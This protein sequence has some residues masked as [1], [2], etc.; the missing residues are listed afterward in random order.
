MFMQE[1]YATNSS[2]Q[3]FKFYNIIRT[4]KDSFKIL[5]EVLRE[6]KQSGAVTVLT[7]GIKLKADSID[8]LRSMTYDHNSILGKGSYGTMVFKG[9]L[10]PHRIAV[11]RIKLFDENENQVDREIEILKTCDAHENIVR[12]LGSKK[13]DNFVLILLELCDMNLKE[14]VAKKDIAI[15]PLEVLR[16]V[17]VGLEWL[18]EH[19]I[20]HR[21]LKPENILL[22]R[23]PIKVKISDF[24]LS[25]C[26]VE[27]NSFVSTASSVD[28][29][30]G[31]VAPEILLL[32][33]IQGGQEAGKFTYASDIFALGCLYYYI[34]TDGKHA[35]GDNSI[36][37][38][39][40]ILDGKSTIEH[41]DV[42]YGCT[43]NLLFV[44]RMISMDPKL[45]PS[46]SALLSFPIF[47]TR[48][49]RLRFLE[50]VRTHPADEVR[51]NVFN[52]RRVELC[53]VDDMEKS[54]VLRAIGCSIPSTYL[55]CQNLQGE[56]KQYDSSSTSFQITDDHENDGA[57]D[58][59]ASLSSS[60]SA[61]SLSELFNKPGLLSTPPRSKYEY[62]PRYYASTT[63][64]S[65]AE[66]SKP[67]EP[68][69]FVSPDTILENLKQLK[70]AA[71]IRRLFEIIKTDDLAI[72]KV[73]LEI[74]A[75][76]LRITEIWLGDQ[77][78]L[79]HAAVESREYHVIEYLVK[80]Q[81]FAQVL[82]QDRYK[83]DLIHTCIVD[84]DKVDDQRFQEKM[85]ILQLLFESWPQLTESKDTTYSR[86]PLHIATR[87][88]FSNGKK[89]EFI[90][91]L[92]QN[93][94]D[95][96][97]KDCAGQTPLHC[98][99]VRQKPPWKAQAQAQLMEIVKLLLENNANPDAI[100]SKSSTFLHVAALHVTPLIFHELI[101]HLDLIRR[102]KSFTLR[103]SI[104][105]TAL[106]DAI[107]NFE[108]LVTT[109]SVF[110]SN[111]FDFKATD[112]KN[113]DTLMHRAVKAGRMDLFLKVLIDF[114]TDWKVVNKYGDSGLHFA[115][116][117]GNLLCLKCLISLGADVNAKTFDGETPL[118]TAFGYRNT[119][120][121][122][123]V[124]LLKNGADPNV[125]T[126]T[127]KLPLH[128]AEERA[129]SGHVEQKT[130]EMLR[131]LQHS[132]VSDE[133]SRKNVTFTQR[134][135]QSP[136]DYTRYPPPPPLRFP[137]SASATPQRQPTQGGMGGVYQ[138][139]Y[140]FASRG[141]H[142]HGNENFRP[143]GYR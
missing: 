130:V 29:T 76:K 122:I 32:Q 82:S 7:D 112:T 91:M 121:E 140:R 58:V 110:K 77:K 119:V 60:Q 41:K 10:G 53:K 64:L 25:R 42:R 1:M 49:R 9:K 54:Q 131:N 75:K 35:F 120:H 55:M 143:R 87:R 34:L 23:K 78:T 97:A 106:H 127:G 109:L 26:I 47:W 36:R 133:G 99:V 24:G 117:F 123:V 22:K 21:D 33:V 18:H 71:K 111:G 11:K 100:D 44:K 84:I 67:N 45:R 13:D 80:T 74:V 68:R 40:N 2:T 126:K 65:T 56:T 73:A 38:Q 20:I 98:C 128:L 138:Q 141:G 115:A 85:K 37:S 63:D 4:K 3:I 43:Q 90:Q 135:S 139:N 39:A 50:D 48:E 14:W 31:W 103:N 132:G 104:G 51:R 81:G 137:P 61:D 96:N 70:G 57:S 116:F 86:T 105:S 27:G 113:G 136:F 93:N 114:G 62:K 129:K 15:P 101:V 69:K 8:D 19:R 6:T 125:P 17:T 95:V 107:H 92:L 28:G 5:I 59:D 79:L 89:L 94:A 66:K 124:E 46:C 118:H 52:F 108:V 72:I 88:F 30:I 12:C 16:Q 83:N 102:T 134:T 142:V